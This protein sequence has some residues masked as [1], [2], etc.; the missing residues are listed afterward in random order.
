MLTKEAQR[1]RKDLHHQDL[2]KQCGVGRVRQGCRGAHNAD[3]QAAGQVGPAWR[4]GEAAAGRGGWLA[5]KATGGTQSAI[6]RAQA[7]AVLGFS[8]VLCCCL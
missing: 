1:G 3:R 5:E 7:R 8:L 6:A 4:G 2:Y